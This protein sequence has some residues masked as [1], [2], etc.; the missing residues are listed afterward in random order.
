MAAQPLSSY[1]VG[2]LIKEDGDLRY[3]IAAAAQ[4]QA[5]QA[6]VDIGDPE[7]WAEEHA[8]AYAM[9]PG[10]VGKVESALVNGIVAW[11]QDPSVISDQ[12]ILSWVQPEIS[13][14]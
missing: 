3:R 12:D 10:W 9:A 5:D 13:G 4:Q 14:A 2:Y 1:Y 6:T 11:G 8:W 7:V